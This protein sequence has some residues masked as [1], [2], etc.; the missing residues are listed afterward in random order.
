MRPVRTYVTYTAIYLSVIMLFTVSAVIT[1]LYWKLPGSNVIE[2]ILL[3]TNN[4][5]V[6]S[7]LFLIFIKTLFVLLAGLILHNTFKKISSP[8]IFFFSLAIMALSFTSLRSLFLID[9][10]LGYPLYLSETISRFVYFGRLVAILC[11]FTSGLFSTGITFQKQD[12]FLLLIILISF[13][14][15]SNIPIDLF[16]TDTILLKGTGSEYGMN[17]VFILLQLFSI[18]NFTVGA[19]KNNN[20]EYLFLALGVALIAAGNEFLFLLIPGW[21]SLLAIISLITGTIIFG[22]KT[23][24]IYQWT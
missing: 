18:L 20:S 16:K 15:S 1:F 9:E 7:V 14:L 3:L 4:H 12:S 6:F 5:N 19:I 23:H 24:K 22:Y 2:T 11:L 8:E 13:V 10:F 17:I 21:I